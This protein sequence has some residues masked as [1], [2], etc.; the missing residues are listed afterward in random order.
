[1]KA[2]VID[3][4]DSGPRFADFAEPAVTGGESLIEVTAAGQDGI[5]VII[6]YLWG[7][8]TERR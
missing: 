2:A 8:P 6:D 7:Q 3:S 5:H 4:L 1:M